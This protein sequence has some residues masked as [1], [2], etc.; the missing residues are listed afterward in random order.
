MAAPKFKFP[1]SADWDSFWTQSKQSFSY[2]RISWSKRRIIR[3][4]G[5]YLREGRKALDAG[6]GSGF[7]ARLFCDRKMK[8]VA[9]DYSPQAVAM[10]QQLTEGKVAVFQ[11]NL[12]DPNMS[13]GFGEKFDL[14]FTDGLFEHFLT[15]EQDIIMQNL[16]ALL[17]PQGVI[18][19]FVPNRWSPW[20]IIRPF[21]MPG[22]EEKPF[23]LKELVDL[24]VRNNLR[25]I[26][27]GGVNT[28]PFVF[29]PEGIAPCCGMLLYTIAQ[30]Q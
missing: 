20:E 9:I 15:D 5:P 11:K 8:T 30:A 21:F 6:C 1:Q 3:V 12:L 14:I 18:I 16:T 26:E 13:A 25:V 29:S 27:K 19:T 22:I 2:D 4:L 28:L 24:N 7:F 10:T 17:E 23:V